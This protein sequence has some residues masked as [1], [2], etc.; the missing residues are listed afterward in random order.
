MANVRIAFEVMNGKQLHRERVTH[1]TV[2]S[3]TGAHVV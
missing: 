3:Q 2:P 1:V